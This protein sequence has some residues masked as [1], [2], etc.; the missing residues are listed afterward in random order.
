[1]APGHGMCMKWIVCLLVLPLLAGCVTDGGRYDEPVWT[2]PEDAIPF[3]EGH[4]HAD[5]ELHRAAANATVLDND[6]LARFGKS[7][8]QVVGAHALA[9][10]ENTLVVAVNA[11]ETNGGQQGFH[12]FDVSGPENL[13]HLGFWDA[14]TEVNGDRTIALSDDG[15]TVFLGFESGTRPGIAAISIAD[16]TNP[17]EVGFWSDPLD[18]GPHTISTGYFGGTQY[19]FSLSFGVTIFSFDGSEFTTVGRYITADEL[20]LLDGLRYGT[21][22]NT[23][24]MQTFM[25]RSL[26]AHDMNFYMDNGR[27]LLM[28]AYA[29]DG[30]KILDLTVPSAPLLQARWMPPAVDGVKHYT[31][32]MTAERVDGRLIVVVGS[33]TFEDELNHIASPIW[34]LDATGAVAGTPLATAPEHLATWGNPSDAPA[35]RLGLS[36]HFFRQLDGFLYLSHYHGGVWA[37]DLTTD[38]SRREMTAIG[39]IMPIPEEPAIPFAECCIGWDLSGVPMVFDV[40]VDADHNVYA[41]DIIQGVSS[42]RFR[43]SP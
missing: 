12:V 3:G 15:Q 37:F 16:P 1:M 20:A 42:L 30:A 31:H 4:D 2:A 41:A 43:G 21:E 32:S 25:V 17:V 28:V 14:G 38:E 34:I 24:Y 23:A 35:G 39:F 36:V 5:P 29:Y 9:I 8:D 27:P 11:G 19:V 33:E 18:F 40:A 26:F 13:T 7:V 22:G 10:H 6:N